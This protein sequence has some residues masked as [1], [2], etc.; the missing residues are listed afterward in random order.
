MPYI[1]REERCQYDE[2]LNQIKEIKTK[3]DLEYCI[4]K[5]MVKFMSNREK[6]YST[7]HDCVYAA[8]HCGDEFRRQ[9]LDLREN[10]AIMENGDVV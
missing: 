9:N 3:G 4:F 7:L 2:V 5:L 8:I 10:V 1:K 6:R